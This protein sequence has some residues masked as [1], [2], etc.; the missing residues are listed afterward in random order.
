M[1]MVKRVT[2]LCI[3]YHNKI[4]KIYLKIIKLGVMA[5]AQW[6][7]NLTSNDDDARSIPNLNGLRIQHCCELWYRS[8]R[9]LRSGAVVAVA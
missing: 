1:K 4:Y 3:F 5:V 9:W 6:D 2:M 7:A 8:Q